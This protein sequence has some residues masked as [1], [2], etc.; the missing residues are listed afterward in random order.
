[1]GVMK[2]ISIKGNRVG[3]DYINR[4]NTRHLT[5]ILTLLKTFGTMNYTQLREYIGGNV[6]ADGLR[7]LAGHGLI[8]SQKSNRGNTIYHSLNIHRDERR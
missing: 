5:R 4:A 6:L 3:T 1:M 7:W 8:V 2:G